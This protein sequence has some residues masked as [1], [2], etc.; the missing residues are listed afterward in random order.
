MLSNKLQDYINITKLLNEY[1]PQ[2]FTEI[3]SY[4]QNYDKTLLKRK[5]GFLKDAGL[6]KYDPTNHLYEIDDPGV[7]VLSFFRIMPSKETIRLKR[8]C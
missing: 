4:F 5:I 8:K 7:K 1:G 3:N 6:I 2:T